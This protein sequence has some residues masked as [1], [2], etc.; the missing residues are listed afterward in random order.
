MPRRLRVDMVGYYHVLNRGVEQRK[1]YK[2]DEDFLRFLKI[3]CDASMLFEVNV[4]SYVLMNNH[5]HLLIE[6]KKENLSKYMKQINATY[7]I[8]FNKKYKRSGY[9]W[10]GR[11]K[12]WYVTDEAYLY[13]LIRYIENNPI[14]AKIVSRLGKY[15][16]SSY[17]AFV[18]K[19]RAV[20]C[21]KNSIMFEQ[22]E[23]IK[24]ME[25]FFELSVDDDML[26]E[27]KKSSNLV[28]ASIKNEESS[29][30]KLRGIFKK[31]KNRDSAIFKAYKEGCTQ[32]DI[33]EFLGLSQ[34]SVSK[35]VKKM[36]DEL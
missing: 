21:I 28:I 19:D 6:T 36:K 13:T 1:I 24:D 15:K 8:Y 34:A 32:T 14:K 9:L 5:Y 26:L 29:T 16:F 23:I 18:K 11:Y 25:E 2:D 33:A 22:F 30:K 27:I 31:E 10:Q 4:H 7:A 12:S 17:N 3:V 35:I 20:E